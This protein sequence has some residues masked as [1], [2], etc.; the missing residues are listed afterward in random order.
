MRRNEEAMNLRT[1]VQ[2]DMNIARSINIDRDFQKTEPIV[3]YHVTA[4]TIEIL[5]RFADALEG[6]K[7]NSWSLTG[8]YGMGKSAFVNYLLSVVGHSSEPATEIALGKIKTVD[9]SLYKRLS[10]NVPKVAGESG[11]F[12][13]PITAAY[14]PLNSS[15]ARGLLNALQTWKARDEIQ[16]VLVSMLNDK[17]VE[18]SALFELYRQVQ[19]ELNQPMIIIIDEFGKNLDYMSTHYDSGDIFIIQ[20]LA[21]MDSVYLW[22]CLHQAF[23]GYASGLSSLQR[24]E[25]SKVQGRFEDISFIESNSQMLYLMGKALKHNFY[26]DYEDYLDNW[27]ETVFQFINDTDIANRNDFTVDKIRDIYPFHPVT[28]VALIELCTRFAQNDRTLLSFICSNDRFALSSFLDKTNIKSSNSLFSVGLDH[29]YDYF[30]NVSITSYINRAGLQRWVEIH[31]IID[32]NANLSD[33]KIKLLKSVGVLNL[34]SGSLGL[35]ANPETIITTM[36]QT[37]G[38]DRKM[39]KQDLDELGQKGILLYREYA[40]EFRLWEGTD[41]DIPKAINEKR[42]KLEIR[43][44][45]HIL[46][47]YLSL[48]PVIASRHSYQTGTIRQFERKWFSVELL[49]ETLVPQEGFDG[50]I[51]YS[52]GNL[53]RPYIV[54]K[55]CADKRPLVIAYVSSQTTLKELSLDVVAA[56]M[57]LNES[58]ELKNDGV[59]RKEIKFRIKTAED[60]FRLF[61]EQVYTPGSEKITWYVKGKKKRIKNTKMLSTVLSELCDQTYDKCPPIK[62]E[63]VSYENLSSAASR[64]RRVLVEAMITGE[65]KE[66]LGLQGFGPEVAIYNSMLKSEGLHV[67][68]EK[69]GLWK[70]SLGQ[71]NEYQAL[72][73]RLDQF[74]NDAKEGITVEVILS[75]LK[76]PSFGLRQGPAPIYIVLYLM[77]HS[78]SVAVFQEGTYRPYLSAAETALLIKRPDLFTLRKYIFTDIDR[79]VFNTYRK[80]LKAVHIEGKPGLRNINLISVVGPLVSFVENLPEYT[81][82]TRLISREARRVRLA[83]QNSGDPA[84][85]IFK[86]LPEAVG[87]K[88]ET[89]AIIL[90]D[91]CFQNKLSTA[92]HELSNVF[93]RLNQEIQNAML[94][95]FNYAKLDELAEEQRSRANPL[96]NICDD[97]EMKQFLQ[98]MARE[99]DVSEWVQGVASLVLGKPIE[100]WN[101]GD[102]AIFQVRLHDY[103]NRINHLETLASVRDQLLSEGSRVLS[104]MMPDGTIRRAVI[105]NF[106][107]DDKEKEKVSEIVAELTLE[108][109]QALLSL[110]FEKHLGGAEVEQ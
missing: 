59:A 31:N 1:L 72:W 98:A 33:V 27:A 37:C 62:N 30:F 18:S 88:V 4:K 14:E 97:L 71:K 95:A 52:F 74:L 49:D 38:I 73:G 99:R 15:I 93:S 53:E 104:M 63:M 43:D 17:T 24:K 3:N 44:L 23:D 64:A 11:F 46:Q 28:A 67:K 85:L 92:L 86:E 25:W 57:V 108:Q 54:P 80:L 35:R 45:E 82:N 6:E 81:K 10:T 102:F 2:P 29:L 78:E 50:L 58:N 65:G 26:D 89:G 87:A 56:R 61:L 100:S 12:R 79:A 105:K 42:E 51:V 70:F 107:K 96:I 90:T 55:H 32:G 22:V 109:E 47:E 13:V 94:S 8:P 106:S 9:A 60:N 76:E 66:S 91:S 40:N 110:L 16:R 48:N 101:D 83:I 77:V 84:D 34:L 19:N 36:E 75:S 20:Q 5:S 21:E 7:V 69:T 39:I 41:F 103:A 68:D